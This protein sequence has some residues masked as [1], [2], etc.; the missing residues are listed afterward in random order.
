MNH[1]T[2]DND[3]LGR[4]PVATCE[5]LMGKTKLSE[6]I[7]RERVLR[8]MQGVADWIETSTQAD[9]VEGKCYRMAVYDVAGGV[10]WMYPNS[11]TAETISAW[12]DMGDALGRPEFT[13]KAVEYANALIE[14]HEYGLYAGPA[15]EAEGLMWYWTDVGSYSTLYS[16]RIPRAFMRLYDITG[17]Q[18]LL[19][20]CKAIGHTLAREQL[21]NGLIGGGW[22]PKKGWEEANDRIGSRYAYILATFANLYKLTSEKSYR[23]AYERAVEG[24]LR[25]QLDDGSFYQLYDIETLG[26]TR[27]GRS[28]KCMF[29]AYIFNALAEAYE[30]MRDPRLLECATK[31]GDYIVR[32]YYCY[33]ALP[34]CVGPDILPSDLPEMHMSTYECANGM[35]WLYRHVRDERFKD[36]GL[37]LWM[38]ACLNQADTPDNKALHG[39]ILIGSD[40]TCSTSIEGIPENR[41]HLLYDPRRAAKCVLWGMVNH[42]FAGKQILESPWL[43]D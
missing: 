34:Y 13:A 23:Q 33:G 22:S 11:N 30:I 12:L 18:R 5:P 9:P 2:R 1:M 7:T 27:A 4:S 20:K 35:L 40:P 19:D 29:F 38:S 15:S 3:G 14:N 42:V 43:E 24:V 6:L 28:V 39:A 26:V 10:T 31:L 37:R 32:V 16:M 17:D 21:A 36:I 8:S 41:K 25:M